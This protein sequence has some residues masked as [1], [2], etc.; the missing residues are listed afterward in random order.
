MDDVRTPAAERV[1]EAV[2]GSRARTGALR[3]LAAFG[4]GWRPGDADRQELGAAAEIV[5]KVAR[6]AYRVTDEDVARAR[7]AGLGED[8]LFELIVATAAGAGMARRATGSPTRSISHRRARRH[9]PP[10]PAS[11]RLAVTPDSP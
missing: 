11:W 10:A 8:E 3:R 4:H 7:R 2:L 1:A 5:D 6:H 9:S